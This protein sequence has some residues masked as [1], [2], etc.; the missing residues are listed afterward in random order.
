MKFALLL[1]DPEGY[2]DAVSTEEMASA[3]AAHQAFA[4]YLDGR[5]VAYTGQALHPER[6][7]RTLRP[8]ADGPAATGGPFTPRRAEFAGFYVVECTDLDEAE[9]VARK[10]PIGA[11]IEIRPI[12]EV[13]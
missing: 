12:W 11:G 13:P 2:W 4:R 3:L 5:G 6:E 8:A 9:E 10:C 7:A 1:F